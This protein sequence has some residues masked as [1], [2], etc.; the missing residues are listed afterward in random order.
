MAAVVKVKH[1]SEEEPPEG[2]IFSSKRR[3]L[4]DF[5]AIKN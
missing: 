3:K 5:G 2:L 4:D 1:R